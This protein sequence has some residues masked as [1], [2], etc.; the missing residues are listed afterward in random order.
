MSDLT[1]KCKKCGTCCR[2]LFV[3]EYGV[4]SGLCLTEEEAK[5]FDSK[6]IMPYLAIGDKKPTTIIYY[7][8]VL[9]DCPHLN[10][11]NECKIYEKRPLICRVFPV[12]P[13]LNGIVILPKCPEILK[14]WTKEG[15]ISPVAIE[16]DEIESALTKITI[17]SLTHK[18]E[19]IEK[20]LRFWFFD[21][22]TGKWHLPSQ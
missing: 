3:E 5:Q 16:D 17:L 21:L 9:S 20:G 13:D 7:Q 11:K 18:K 2:G 14:H 1:F 4:L 8:L 19:C 12:H 22:A 6:V 10:G 15:E